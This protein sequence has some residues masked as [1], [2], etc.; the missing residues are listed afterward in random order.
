M[1][2]YKIKSLLWR[3]HVNRYKDLTGQRFGKLTVKSA[4]DKRDKYKCKIWLCDCDCGK[5]NIEVPTSRLN[6]RKDG[7]RSC[8]CLTRRLIDLKGKRFSSLTVIKKVKHENPKI[9]SAFWLCK[10]DCGKCITPA[11]SALVSGATT[12]CG[13]IQKERSS[14]VLK[15]NREIPMVERTNLASLNRKEGINN[16]SGVKGVSWD[17]KSKKWRA[18]IGFKKETITLGY[19][20]DK[21]D[22]INARKEAEEKY[23]K[24]ILEKYAKD[25]PRP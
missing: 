1:I 17:K 12:S 5:T 8:G 19:F 25:T 10:C 4:T 2:K 13:H 22:A 24:P 11:G 6:L 15:K 7:K 18:R 14:A 21:Q 23:F 9:G 16:T 20:E 3:V